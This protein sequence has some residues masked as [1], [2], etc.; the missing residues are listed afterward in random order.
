LPSITQQPLL[1]TKVEWVAQQRQQLCWAAEGLQHLVDAKAASSS[2]SSN[3]RC[4]AAGVVLGVLVLLHLHQ[5][6]AR[7]SDIHCCAGALIVCLARAG[8]VVV[9]VW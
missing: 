9:R 7:P 3:G 8:T 6:L 4:R 5:Q 1:L 2:S